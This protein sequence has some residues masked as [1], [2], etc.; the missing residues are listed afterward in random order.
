MHSETLRLE[1]P[2]RILKCLQLYDPNDQTHT[3]P[4]TYTPILFG[5]RVSCNL[6][7]PGAYCAAED[8]DGLEVLI[9]LPLPTEK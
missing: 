1:D 5:D 3:C 6:G 9:L 4:C 2:K 7:W 8:E